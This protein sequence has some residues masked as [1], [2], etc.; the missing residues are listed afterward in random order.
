MAISNGNPALT[1][2]HTPLTTATS[3]KISE[4]QKQLTDLNP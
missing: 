2:H 3:E 1:A 4:L